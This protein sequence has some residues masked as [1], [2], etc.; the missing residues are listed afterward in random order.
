MCPTLSVFGTLPKPARNHPL[1]SEL[2]REKA[3]Y[4]AMKDVRSSFAKAKLQFAKKHTH[5]PKGKES[6]AELQ[7]L[8][9]GAPVYV[10]RDITQSWQ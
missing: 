5:V 2:Q 1:E 6:T 9:A 10:Q 7:K 8:P 3:R 4:S